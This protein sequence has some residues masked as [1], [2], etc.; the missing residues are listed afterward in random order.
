MIHTDKTVNTNRIDHMCASG[1]DEAQDVPYAAITV[2]EAPYTITKS[3]KSL[4]NGKARVAEGGAIGEGTFNVVELKNSDHFDQ[5]F[6]SFSDKQVPLMGVPSGGLKEG[7]IATVGDI[8]KG[9]APAGAIA[10]SLS[11]FGL[12]G[13]GCIFLDVDDNLCPNKVLEEIYKHDP[14]LNSA[15]V[16]IIPSAR[17]HV[18]DH[19]GNT[20]IEKGGHH[21]YILVSNRELLGS[22]QRHFKQLLEDIGQYT[23]KTTASGS[24]M[25]EFFMDFSPLGDQ[26]IRECFESVRL[27][28]GWTAP[29]TIT[30][31]NK[32]QV[33]SLTKPM[34][35]H[36]SPSA[37]NTT[38]RLDSRIP[39]TIKEVAAECGLKKQGGNA[40]LDPR[41]G[42][43][44]FYSTNARD[45]GDP[46]FICYHANHPITEGGEKAYFGAAAMLAHFVCSGSFKEAY[47]KYGVDVS[48][49]EQAKAEKEYNLNGAKNFKIRNALWNLHLANN[50]E[51]E[52][53]TCWDGEAARHARLLPGDSKA[54]TEFGDKHGL[55][56]TELS[57]DEEGRTVGFGPDG[58]A[59][60]SSVLDRALKD[61]YAGS[62]KPLAGEW[63]EPV[64]VASP[65]EAINSTTD[66]AFISAPMGSGKSQSLIPLV[67]AAQEGGGKISINN[68]LRSLSGT[69]SN[70]TGAGH[71]EDDRDSLKD[72]RAVV[73]CFPSFIS[74]RNLTWMGLNDLEHFDPADFPDTVVFDEAAAC[75][76]MLAQHNGL[77]SEKNKDLI[78][79]SLSILRRAGV[80][81]VLMDATCPKSL[82]SFADFL[83]VDSYFV[84]P[85]PYEQPEINFLVAGQVEEEGK[86]VPSSPI[87]NHVPDSGNVVMAVDSV[88]QA[89]VYAGR[90]GA[91]CLT[92][93]T[94]GEP[95]Q[96]ALLD[97]PN[98][99]ALR[100]TNSSQGLRVVY[101]GV[102]SSGFSVTSVET[103]VLAIYTGA[104][105]IQ[106]FLQG[107]RR[108]RLAKGQKI[109]VQLDAR[110][111]Q[112]KTLD[113]VQDERKWLS[114][115]RK[116]G[117]SQGQSGGIWDAKNI[118]KASALAEKERLEE[119]QAQSLYVAAKEL[120]FP[121]VV[122]EQDG[123]VAD[124]SLKGEKKQVKQKQ[125]ERVAK[126]DVL[127]P[128]QVGELQRA[129]RYTQA[130]SD[131]MKATA[132]ADALQLDERDEDAEK[133]G[134]KRDVVEAFLR[135]RLGSR[136]R[137]LVLARRDRVDLE[138]VDLKQHDLA[139]VVLEHIGTDSRKLGT[140]TKALDA[141]SVEDLVEKV[142][143][144][145][146]RESSLV[147][148][149]ALDIPRL[150]SARAS[151]S[152]KVKW[153]QD[154]L[155]RFGCKSGRR[156][157][158]KAG[159]NAALWQIDEVVEC[160]SGRHFE[161]KNHVS[162]VRSEVIDN[163]Q[164]GETL[165][166]PRRGP[167]HGGYSD[168]GEKTYASVYG[169]IQPYNSAPKT[170]QDRVDNF[171]AT[172]WPELVGTDRMAGLSGAANDM[173][174]DH[175]SDCF[176]A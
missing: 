7:V 70:D 96:R 147:E 52:V 172:V 132:M 95:A 134:V 17:H 43:K 170:S 56:T 154:L 39:M 123:D 10:R 72:H 140:G 40:W 30:T 121:V 3:V 122:H 158:T 50:A 11:Y 46:L 13:Q 113:S 133:G 2:L 159:K 169:V 104:V 139:N 34:R 102:I 41:E 25:K 53:N 22:W 5:V 171:I 142:V 38:V 6:L 112:P 119:C 110:A 86:V 128:Q 116:Y 160:F 101:T 67:K 126:A 26:A 76:D 88:S 157:K 135:K 64:K 28:K 176:A 8:D 144:I 29:R 145:V 61:A 49:E 118:I 55:D 57:R 98:D 59:H 125:V 32:G 77:I 27:P 129:S 155:N 36:G 168:V 23:E 130:E 58:G 149:Q 136:V 90:L 20:R 87:L 97:N 93:E 16:K 54:I 127:N 131:S 31:R 120:G 62:M 4:P 148:V 156:T 85:S 174:S 166:T 92:A 12:E 24:R 15:E 124:T 84:A 71:Y 163:P 167:S 91:L 47:K 105:P 100:L 175:W 44:R 1:E 66:S 19:L 106:V 165:A 117:V 162:P 115:F 42:D 153:R 80:R 75:A 81:F 137:R 143:A 14:S 69:L 152:V 18:K 141:A 108:F 79:E 78:L 161:E 51:S 111:F 60:I 164:T 65:S 146:P 83:G 82:R 114:H 33:G 103:D 138:G 73:C 9:T 74:P 37:S 109:Y 107:L 173:G 151:R 63:L 68:P 45:S 94:S 21:I 99:E 35:L 48:G 89:E 150:P